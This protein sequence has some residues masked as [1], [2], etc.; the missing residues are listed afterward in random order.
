MWEV[1]EK[2]TGRESKMG[3]FP[4]ETAKIPKNVVIMMEEGGLF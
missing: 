3:T 1:F 4:G 2:L